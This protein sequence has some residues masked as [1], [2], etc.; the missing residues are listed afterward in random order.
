MIGDQKR[1]ARLPDDG[2]ANAYLLDVEVQQ[3]SVRIKSRTPYH[4]QIEFELPNRVGGQI[5]DQ[6]AIGPA[7]ATACDKDFAS[8]CIVFRY[9]KIP[10]EYYPEILFIIFLIVMLAKVYFMV[11]LANT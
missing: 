1:F 11:Q 9:K 7:Q 6:P 2:L 5:A 4:G 3:V 10:K 8:I